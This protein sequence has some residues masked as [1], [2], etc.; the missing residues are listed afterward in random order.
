M[1]AVCDLAQVEVLGRDVELKPTDT[2]GTAR[3]VRPG[4]LKSDALKAIPMLTDP[5]RDARPDR[6]HLLD[7]GVPFGWADVVGV[8]PQRPHRRACHRLRARIDHCLGGIDRA[9]AREQRHG[10]TPRRLRDCA[11]HRKCDE[12]QNCK[13]CRPRRKETLVAGKKPVSDQEHA[14]CERQMRERSAGD[15]HCADRAAP[16][17]AI[18]RSG[19]QTVPSTPPR[20]KSAVPR[21]SGRT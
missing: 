11:P 14:T 10:G 9:E 6:G 1:F 4:V 12:R 21:R 17:P 7:Q 5:D 8:H 19:Q 18:V 20:P 15:E 2:V 3:R 16:G 13:Q